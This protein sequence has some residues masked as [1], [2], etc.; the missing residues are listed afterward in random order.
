MCWNAW[1]GGPATALHQLSTKRM[2]CIVVP[3]H[4]LLEGFALKGPV[5]LIGRSTSPAGAESRLPSVW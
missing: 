4:D 1:G 2:M 3:L 5:L